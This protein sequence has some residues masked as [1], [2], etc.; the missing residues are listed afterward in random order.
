MLLHLCAGACLAAAKPEVGL[1]MM[2][3]AIEVGS[4]SAART[5]T[6]EFLIRMAALLLAVSSDH[7]AEAEALYQQAVLNAQEVHANA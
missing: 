3:E 2:N 1:H 5:G 7:A 6:S 4:S